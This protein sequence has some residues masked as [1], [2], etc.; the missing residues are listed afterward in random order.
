MNG[1]QIFVGRQEELEEFKKVLENPQGQA[2]LVIGQVGMGKTF[3]VN[4]MAQIAQ[5]HPDLKCGCVRYEVTPTDSVDSTMALMM[6]NAFEAA[7]TEAGSFDNVPE[8]RKQWMALLKTIVPKGDKIAELIDSL[9]R[10]PAKNTRDQFLERLNLISKKM[11]K[12]GRAIFIIDPEKY[13]QEKSDQSWAI[14]V[15]QL[16]EKIK[17]VF[18]Q[19]NEDM[20][21][22]S[23]VFNELKNVVRIPEKHL[24]VLDELSVDELIGLESANIKYPISE[25]KK[26]ISGHD[27]HPYAIGAALGL[28]KAGVKLEKLPKR[29]EPKKF[30]EMQWKEIC[31]RSEEAIRLFRAYAILEVGV[32]NEIIEYVSG[33]NSYQ[34]QHL[35]ADNYLKGLLREE[36][37]GKRIYHSIL[38]DYILGQMNDE[39]KKKYHKQAVKIYRGKLKKAKEEQIKPDELAAIRLSEHVLAAEGNDTFV[40]VFINEC[41]KPLFNLGTFDS[42][43]NLSHRALK[44]VE[45]DSEDETMLLGNLSNVYLIRGE[46]N[47]AEKMYKE[48]LLIDEKFDRL[49]GMAN[50]YGNLGNLYIT[51]NDL[52]K[53]EEMYIKV[54]EIEKKLGRLNSIAK[55]CGSL[56]I[57]YRQRGDLDEAEKMCKTALSINEKF[58]HLEGIAIGYSNLGAIYQ[59]R[60]ELDK[61]AEIYKKALA[62][63]EKLGKLEGMAYGYG[64]L[65]LIYQMRGD[66]NEAEKMY[67]KSL[68]INNKIGRLP[69]IAAD[70]YNL[71]GLYKM[72]SDFKNA[73]EYWIKARDLY[74]KIGII[75]E[76][77]E[78]QGLIDGLK[79]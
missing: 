51:R 6:D 78:L 27:G 22:D 33:L 41:T 76:V 75:N 43:I 63:N 23:E 62:I 54:L 8:R 17:F 42:Y 14:V 68:Q 10:D 65:G 69:G 72:R 29:P 26:V 55:A 13:M 66:L 25:I 35:L 44:M 15:K 39:E 11:P 60:G 53:A 2:V 18:A 74:Q 30:A 12:N 20:L 71:G 52:H 21:V 61:A 77:K 79:I 40:D 32:P 57:I 47:E 36:G 67:K 4:K 37:E 9:R 16:P 73:K 59:K 48:V 31:K 24:D 5:E 3:L 38:T 58:K 45:K 56:S 1:K 19:R 70:Y 49:E 28:L 50:Q 46:L 64:N 7:A 34:I